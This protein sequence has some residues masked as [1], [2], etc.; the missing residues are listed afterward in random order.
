MPA[1]PAR[2]AQITQPALISTSSDAAVKTVSASA[3]DIEIASA[4]YNQ[5][6]ADAENLR[7]FT[8]MKVARDIFQVTVAEKSGLYKVGQTITLTYPRFGLAAG[9]NFMIKGIAEQYGRGLTILTLWG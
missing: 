3:R 9:R 8:L 2:I 1:S 4:L 7:Q 6:D 5:I